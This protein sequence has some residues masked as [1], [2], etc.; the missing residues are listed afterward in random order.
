M[1]TAAKRSDAPVAQ[2]VPWN[3]GGV[4]AP[5]P[6]T[7]DFA[8]PPTHVASSEPPATPMAEPQRSVFSGEPP[9]K[10]VFAPSAK[11]VEEVKENVFPLGENDPSWIELVRFAQKHGNTI[12]QARYPH[13]RGLCIDTMYR[14]VTVFPHPTTQVRHV[15]HGWI[16]WKDAIY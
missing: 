2:P 15:V 14:G 8:D 13:P 10:S 12:V 1:A 11:K 4:P 5:A 16:D 6:A 3:G 9:K 7:P